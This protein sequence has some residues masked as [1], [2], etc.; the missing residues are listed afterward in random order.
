MFLADTVGVRAAQKHVVWGVSSGGTIVILVKLVIRIIAILATTW[1][2][3]RMLMI[4]SLPR[5]TLILLLRYALLGDH[6]LAVL[7][8]CEA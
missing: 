1:T 3:S 6:P 8:F 4:T 7:L 5:L 2:T